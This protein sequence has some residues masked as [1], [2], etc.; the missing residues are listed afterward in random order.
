MAIELTYKMISGTWLKIHRESSGRKIM[1]SSYILE[2]K[3]LWKTDFKEQVNTKEEGPWFLTKAQLWHLGCCQ[4]AGSRFSSRNVAFHFAAASGERR[5]ALHRLPGG[6]RGAFRFR[7]LPLLFRINSSGFFFN[8]NS[9][10]ARSFEVRAYINRICLIFS[11]CGGG[12]ARKKGSHKPSP[13]VNCGRLA[14]THMQDW[15]KESR[16]TLC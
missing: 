3:R 10:S 14:L 13:A 9:V 5:S 16:T 2:C 7:A 11:S 15:R 6:P 4:S 12:K 1:H 8:D